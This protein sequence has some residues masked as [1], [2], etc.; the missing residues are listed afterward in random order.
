L[1]NKIKNSESASSEFFYKQQITFD[2]TLTI[3]IPKVKDHLQKELNTIQNI[4]ILAK[5]D[6]LPV[7]LSVLKDSLEYYKFTQHLL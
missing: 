6:S 1:L 5:D 7:L 3:T 4:P 2:I